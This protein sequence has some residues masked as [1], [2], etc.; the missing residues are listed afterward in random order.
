MPS[1][2]EKVNPNQ[3]KSSPWDSVASLAGKMGQL[4]GKATAFAGAVRDKAFEQLRQ[5]TLN[6]RRKEALD[7]F[8]NNKDDIIGEPGFGTYEPEPSEQQRQLIEEFK[9]K[10][11]GLWSRRFAEELCKASQSNHGPR[12]LRRDSTPY[13]GDAWKF[14]KKYDMPMSIV[15]ENKDFYKGM[16]LSFERIG[17]GKLSEIYQVMSQTEEGKEKFQHDFIESHRYRGDLVSGI[18]SIYANEPFNEGTMSDLKLLK[19]YDVC[20][21]EGNDCW[22]VPS[23]D[24][25]G[26]ERAVAGTEF[27]IQNH[28]FGGSEYSE[29][30]NDIL[31]KPNQAMEGSFDIMTIASES[32]ITPKSEN[33]DVEYWNN[34]FVGSGENKLKIL[35]KGNP[36]EQQEKLDFSEP[37]VMR[38]FARIHMDDHDKTDTLKTY[39]NPKFREALRNPATQETIMQEIERNIQHKSLASEWNIQHESLASES[40]PAPFLMLVQDRS[41]LDD[42]R[43]RGEFDKYP[44]AIEM[45]DAIKRASEKSFTEKERIELCYGRKQYD[46]YFDEQG[47]P[48]DLWYANVAA[49]NGLVHSDL[50]P[51]SDHEKERIELFCR[52]R[53]SVDKLASQ[54]SKAMI[55]LLYNPDDQLSYWQFFDGSGN[56]KPE[57]YHFALQKGDYA[58]LANQDKNETGFDK[59][60]NAFLKAYNNI[61]SSKIVK[62]A[63]TPEERQE[64]ISKY[65]NTYG[66]KPEFWQTSFDSGDIS[67]LIKQDEETRSKMGLDNVSA[68]LLAA[69]IDNCSHGKDKSFNNFILDISE[70]SKEERRQMGLD[71]A[72]DA[73]LDSVF[74]YLSKKSSLIVSDRFKNITS[75]FD[76]NTGMPTAEFWQASLDA[77]DFSLLAKQNSG[78]RAA[79]MGFDE[80]INVFIDYYRTIKDSTILEEAKTHNKVR[81]TINQYFTPD[82]PKPEFWQDSLAA[83]NFKLLT[84]QDEETRKSMGFD[85]ATMA[86]LDGVA[87]RVFAGGDERNIDESNIIQVLTRFIDKDANDWDNSSEDDLLIKEAF[88]NNH[89]K[90]LCLAKLRNMYGK[91]LKSSG[92]TQFPT[93]LRSMADYMHSKGGAGPLTQIEAFLD[94]AG[95]LGDSLQNVDSGSNWKDRM[96]ANVATIEDTMQKYRWDNQEKTNFYATSAEI[97]NANPEL[98]QEFAKLFVNNITKEEFKVFTNEIYP[99]YRAKLALL[100]KYEDHSDGIGVGYTTIKYDPTDIKVL[101]NQL[102]TALLPFNCKEVSKEKRQEGIEKVK[103]NIFN[104]VS[105]LFKTRFSI[106]PEAIPGELSKADA[107]A[108]GDMTRYLG[109]LAR[110]NQ[111][112][113]DILGFY[114]ALQL[115]KDKTAWEKLR[116]GEII[117]PSKYLDIASSYNV[118]QALELSRKKNPITLER[119]RI[120]SPKRLA[121]F[122]RAMQNETVS[123]RSGNIQTVDLKLENLRGNMEELTDPDLYPEGIDRQR[124][125]LLRELPSRS[126]FNKVINV[127][128]QRMMGKDIPLTNE[129]QLIN[130]RVGQILRD[131]GLEFNKDNIQQ[132]FQTDM[133]TLQ[134]PFNI[135][136]SMKKDGVADSIKELRTM[137]NPPDNVVQILE[138]LGEA[139]EP[140]SGVTALGTEIDDLEN[141]MVKKA[142]ELTEDESNVLKEYLNTV[143]KKLTEL[144]GIYSRVIDSYNVIKRNGAHPSTVNKIKEIDKII[145]DKANQSTITTTCTNEMTT[146]IE[147][148]RACLSC[149]T[150]GINNDT[151]LTFGEGYKFYLYSSESDNRNSSTA[152]EIVYFVPTEDEGGKNKRLSFVMDLVY[153]MKNSDILMAHT[154]TILKKAHELK[155]E[156]PEVP[157]SVILPESSILSC[158]ANVD[159]MELSK[160]LDSGDS[161]GNVDGKTVIVP[162]SGFGDHYI[163]LNKGNERIP[164]SRAVSGIEIVINPPRMKG[165]SFFPIGEDEVSLVANLEKRLYQDNILQ[166]GDS[167]YLRERLSEPGSEKFSFIVSDQV[168]GEQQP[169]GY[170][171]AS[172]IEEPMSNESHEG[173][174]VEISDFGIIPEDR[175]GK[176]AWGTLLELLKRTEADG[177]DLIEMEAL[178]DTSYKAFSSKR[179]REMLARQGYTVTDHGVHDRWTIENEDGGKVVKNSY[180]I[181]LKKTGRPV[182]QE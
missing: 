69:F 34:V 160:K 117:S 76:K 20:M 45:N 65:F 37:P 145:S 146:I 116:S 161:F 73:I 62:E 126:E 178:E 1:R 54:G 83:K 101:K 87:G 173:K 61:S 168:K 166:Y 156:F 139:T 159:A 177:V 164:G 124:I 93:V 169:V 176:A 7:F 35:I 72:S 5:P 30:I 107:R 167:S 53:G 152:D 162:M 136:E 175:S 180:L 3:P 52:M 119:T 25:Q 9:K 88:E 118:E 92:K 12:G 86:F 112:K 40:P 110:P 158:S 49:A 102:H 113:K 18:N 170:C 43:E 133:K 57:F 80:T 24:K 89:V 143:R 165:I 174:V 29:V 74:N 150:K 31:L 153:G 66:P 179:M 79:I 149:V 109:S 144:D 50:F 106:R 22:R 97:I 141:L 10:S 108:I 85:E 96:V 130:D 39:Q 171:M 19:Q 114:L 44:K 63:H 100:R 42:M 137:L 103:E 55:E 41:I 78:A 142:N 98:F 14:A 125:E 13:Y 127:I 90:D 56:L 99:L 51:F 147:N 115:D 128:Q 17:N 151:N 11:E 46:G 104:E 120:I 27:L 32:G 60:T 82:G 2:N 154:E 77:G 163:E 95:A 84:G 47:E 68:N 8:V 71:E 148:M 140:Q 155:S 75:L 81:E 157:I 182:N 15:L 26:R 132:Y 23:Y 138:K 36:L 131:N 111:Q 48:N 16:V 58:F 4:G 172:Y 91:Y 122:R 38:L 105:E 94:Y 134:I 129:G 28:L 21:F 135:L 64:I 33:P 70:V 59:T 181:T 67:F 121:E 123:K 6:A